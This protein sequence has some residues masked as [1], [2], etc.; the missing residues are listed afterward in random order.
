MSSP[1]PDGVGARLA[2]ERALAGAGFA[3]KEIDYINLHG[4]ATL[5]GD[6][7]EDRAVAELFGAVTPCSSTKGYTGHT[8][9]ASGIIE[10]L[11]SALSILNG[12]VYGSVHTRHVD[13]Q[14]RSRYLLESASAR[15]DRV[16]SN[17]F[18]F[19]GANC[20][21]LLGRAA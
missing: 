15:V 8:L 17:S 4:T 11:F 18:G 3:P 16:I 20:S 6:A 10:A 12:V 1:H 14:F 13:P 9:G 19:G 21:L 5:V 7:A 2:M